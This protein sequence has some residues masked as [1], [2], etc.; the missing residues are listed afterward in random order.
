MK[1]STYRKQIDRNKVTLDGEYYYKAEDVDEILDEIDST[2]RDVN[3]KIDDITDG[4][5]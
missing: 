4:L 2:L 3:S 5:Y 1:L